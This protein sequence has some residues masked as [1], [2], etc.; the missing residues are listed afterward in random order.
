MKGLLTI[1]FLLALCAGSLGLRY[2][3]SSQNTFVDT[4][5]F[6]LKHYSNGT[7]EVLDGSRS[8]GSMSFVVAG[9]GLLNSSRGY[10]W[11]WQTNE[12]TV[13][14]GE[15]T[16]L[17]PATKLTG[18]NN[19]ALFSLTQEWDFNESLMNPKLSLKF[20]PNRK[21]LS[22]VI[23]FVQNI[24]ENSKVRLDGEELSAKTGFVERNDIEKYQFRLNNDYG[25]DF[26]DLKRTGFSVE[27]VIVGD[28][29]RIGRTGEK[30]FAIGF[31]K[32]LSL[33]AGQEIEL[34]PNFVQLGQFYPANFGQDS[35]DWVNP[36]NLLADD[37][38]SAEA[39]VG[40]FQDVYNFG[41]N[42]PDGAKIINIQ[43]LAQ[44][45]PSGC[46]NPDCSNQ[47]EMEFS[48]DGGTTYTDHNVSH[49]F[50][51]DDETATYALS[52]LEYDDWGV[53]NWLPSQFNDGNFLVRAEL[54]TEVEGDF[55]F[56]PNEFMLD[57]IAAKVEYVRDS[58]NNVYVGCGS[59][60][61]STCDFNYYHL[62]LENE[63]G[64]MDKE[65]TAL[66]VPFDLDTNRAQEYNGQANDQPDY[67]ANRNIC[68]GLNNVAF[69]SN[70]RIGGAYNLIN[71]TVPK[72]SYFQCEGLPHFN[73]LADNDD[74]T[75]GAWTYRDSNAVR[76]AIVSTTYSGG[77]Q[78]SLGI[79]RQLGGPFGT[80]TFRPE[81][82]VNGTRCQSSTHLETGEWHH[83]MAS[84]N[85]ATAEIYIDGSFDTFCVLS[86]S[87]PAIDSPVLIGA[88]R[89]SGIIARFW[90][91]KLDDVFITDT[92]IVGGGSTIPSA[93]YNDDYNRFRTQ[94]YTDLNNQ[95]IG[96]SFN[97][98]DV[99]INGT[100][101]PDTNYSL[102][103][104][105]WNGTN[106]VF[107]DQNYFHADNN[108]GV[109]PVLPPTGSF[110]LRYNLYSNANK[111]YSPVFAHP[112]TINAYNLAY[113]CP[114]SPS[115]DVNISCNLSCTFSSDCDTGGG[116]F[117][118]NND[119]GP[120]LVSATASISGWSEL[121]EE[122]TCRLDSY[123][124]WNN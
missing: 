109:L 67:S 4:H 117:V 69:D 9:D 94:G 72:T 20:K 2:Y 93:I 123:D 52:N 53:K 118:L 90:D 98:I 59:F 17:R 21:I 34:D 27:K 37:G 121:W 61:T 24:K 36:Q 64:F 78:A 23:W 107:A 79:H 35:N 10:S 102:Q 16:G 95:S 87:L 83:V 39:D 62:D 28:G 54:K 82:E 100:R 48:T 114:C 77:N 40:D 70:G 13:R 104:G 30:V 22:P 31:S 103:V 122:Y 49:T 106:Y 12:E 68:I 43:L 33:G 105:K 112:F 15:E 57:Y 73:R 111:T 50:T 113:E 99:N 115:P 92:Q 5:G 71:P 119:N 63:S 42:I 7:I 108:V 32:E 89:P 1:F 45:G 85:G 55:I 11:T 84:Y 86:T 56:E 65:S 6:S 97:T 44:T 25:I 101:I 18:K 124:G 19:S 58:D 60:A 66:Y 96:F 91:G 51:E 29:T 110:S 47:V 46:N 81:F 38:I 14:L 88:A 80:T 26:S 74:I 76:M 75:M 116:K 120:G 3:N 8:L 41:F